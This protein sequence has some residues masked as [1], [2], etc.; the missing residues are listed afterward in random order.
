MSLEQTV[1]NIILYMRKET[2]KKVAFQLDVLKK[3]ST[4]KELQRILIYIM[5]G[6]LHFAKA[7][8]FEV[9]L[10]EVRNPTD[11]N[12]RY[13]LLHEISN[14]AGQDPSKINA[15]DPLHSYVINRNEIFKMLWSH[16]AWKSYHNS[17]KYTCKNKLTAYE[18]LALRLRKAKNV[19]E[20]WS[21]GDGDTLFNWVKDNLHIVPLTYPPGSYYDCYR[22]FKYVE[23]F[24]ELGLEYNKASFKVQKV[25]KEYK[26]RQLAASI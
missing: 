1:K 10:T 7:E 5:Y 23:Y 4:E 17:I 25:W 15:R 11:F 18:N 19:N 24:T 12:C 20:W 16:P 26:K 22:D 2:P 8:N 13:P 14:Q 21:T 6:C 9:L 3:I